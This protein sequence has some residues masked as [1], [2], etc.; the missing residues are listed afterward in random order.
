MLGIHPTEA[1]PEPAVIRR[2]A[3]VTQGI[4]PR[5]EVDEYMRRMEFYGPDVPAE[6]ILENM[7]AELQ[8]SRR[9]R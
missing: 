7:K 2:S 3:P 4:S 1:R 9:W 8:A 6:L 5:D